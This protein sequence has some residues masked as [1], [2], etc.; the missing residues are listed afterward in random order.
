MVQSTRRQ[1]LK[2]A[3][4]IATGLALAGSGV[5]AVAAQARP[6]ALPGFDRT[7][8]ADRAAAVSLLNN[9]APPRPP[10]GEGGRPLL[11]GEKGS[12]P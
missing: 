4:L 8:R 5:S 2:I 1:L 9:Q 7:G 3:S 12:R 6:P 11:P 10:V